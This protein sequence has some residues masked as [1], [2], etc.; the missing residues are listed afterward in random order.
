VP[1]C[2]VSRCRT[3]C[4]LTDARHTTQVRQLPRA[5]SRTIRGTDTRRVCRGPRPTDYG[6]DVAIGAWGVASKRTWRRSALSSRCDGRKIDTA[7]WWDLGGRAV[8][9]TAAQNKN[10]A[11][12]YTWVSLPP[13]TNKSSP[14]PSRANCGRGARYHSHA[15]VK[16]R[17]SQRTELSLNGVQ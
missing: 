10:R 5:A 4:S 7:S 2:L 3:P 12:H 9:E 6:H 16:S 14:H 17:W 13:R 15:R 1:S 11:I 8:C